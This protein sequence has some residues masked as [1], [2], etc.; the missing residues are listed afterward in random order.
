[1]SLKAYQ[2][3]QRITDDPRQTEYR[4]FGEITAAL[5]A[6]EKNNAKGGDLIGPIDWNQKLWRMLAADCL[7]DGNKLQPQVRA[8]IV[9]LSLWVTRYSKKVM[10]ES[11][12]LEPLISVNRSI[13]EGLRGAA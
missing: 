1:M 2:T 3:T 6:A 10:R 4:L 5:V 11:A 9:S 12:P 8:N 13:M 7:D